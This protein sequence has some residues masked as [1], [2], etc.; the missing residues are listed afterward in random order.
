MDTGATCIICAGCNRLIYISVRPVE[1]ARRD[2]MK[3]LR[4][5]LRYELRM[6]PKDD[7]LKLEFGPCSCGGKA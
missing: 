3:T 4:K 6:M 5:G 1:E 2:A 7:A